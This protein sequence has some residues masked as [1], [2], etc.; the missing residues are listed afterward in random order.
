ME[1]S[2]R[3]IEL[4]KQLEI[5]TG[6]VVR[7]PQPVITQ[8]QL[9]EILELEAKILDNERMLK[10]MMLEYKEIGRAPL[11]RNLRIKIKKEKRILTEMRAQ[12]YYAATHDAIIEKGPYDVHWNASGRFV[13]GKLRISR[14]RLKVA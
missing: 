3:I 1:T 10:G 14:Y 6:E 9:A 4:E 7:M 12:I 11:V 8:L 13:R 2:E 5:K